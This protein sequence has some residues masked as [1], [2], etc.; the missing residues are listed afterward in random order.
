MDLLKRQITK[1][2][3]K[4]DKIPSISGLATTPALTAFEN[5]IPSISTLVKKTE[6]NTKISEIEQKLIDHNHDEY[7]TTT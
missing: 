4:E 6:Y 5:K 2:T 3:D 7:I 1:I